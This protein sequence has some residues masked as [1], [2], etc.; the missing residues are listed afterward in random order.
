MASTRQRGRD[1][2]L[3]VKAYYEALGYRCQLAPL[4]TRWSLSND[5]FHLW[6]LV[7]VN[8]LETIWVQIKL[9]KGDSYGKKLDAHRAWPVPPNTR[10]LCVVWPPY[11]REPEISVL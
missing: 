3:K 5:F 8:D 7:G 10:K 4:P 6:D 2:E 1:L 9:N 11:T